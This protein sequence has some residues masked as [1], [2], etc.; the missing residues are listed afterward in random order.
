M[1]ASKDAVLSTNEPILI[2]DLVSM[3]D[4]L[5]PSSWA[6]AYDNVGLLV[7][8]RGV[9]VRGVLT[10]LDVTSAV[11]DEAIARDC[12]VIVAHHP[13]IFRPLKRLTGDNLTARLVA[14]AIGENLAIYAMHT[15]IDNSR[16]GLNAHA[17]GLLKLG[18]VKV[19]APRES[20]LN[21][22]S[23][24]SKLV[25]FV[26]KEAIEGVQQA[27]HAVGAGAIGA[28]DQC[29]F[30][31]LGTGCF[32]AKA[33]A[34]PYKG[35]INELERV[36]EWRLEVIFPSHLHARLE[37]AL[38]ANHPYEEVA[39]YV[40]G[41]DN[42]NQAVGAGIVGE[43]A[44]AMDA[45]AFLAQVAQTFDGLVLQHTKVL[46]KIKRVAFC[47][48]AGGGLISRALGEGADIFITAELKYH[49]YLEYED[50]MMLCDLGHYASESHVKLF[51]LDEIRKKFP[52]IV[53]YSSACCTNPI[54]HYT[55]W[56]AQS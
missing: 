45:K 4:A 2:Q 24:L 6:E 9:A 13:L 10:T 1:T 21:K 5:A 11:L 36:E 30:R 19:L 41:L 56:K 53:S 22:Q 42:T 7:G 43:L 15:N 14:R 38:L 16:Y 46:G 40:Q 8:D 31:V 49:D 17:A 20:G 52:N 47:G 54:E 28:Y 34:K 51:F 3:L 39:Y 48:G 12:N 18:D 23:G 27:L 35:R 55:A 37:Q 26:P 25:C 50:R 33:T 32:R 29:S 44:E